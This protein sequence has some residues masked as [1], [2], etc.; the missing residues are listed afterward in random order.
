MSF[1]PLNKNCYIIK[2]R[3]P[4]KYEGRVQ[5]SSHAGGVLPSGLLSTIAEILI[6]VSAPCNWTYI[7]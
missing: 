4:Q 2:K 5:S 6:H 1:L 7:L 3:A